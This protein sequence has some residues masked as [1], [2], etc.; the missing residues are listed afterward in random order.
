[1]CESR[2]PTD[3]NWFRGDP[4]E[5]SWLEAKHEDADPWDA[6]AGEVGCALLAFGGLVLLGVALLLALLSFF[7]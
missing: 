6:A 3:D 1:M 5:R 4:D 2:R 7:R